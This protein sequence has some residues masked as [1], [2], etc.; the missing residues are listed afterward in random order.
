[1]WTRPAGPLRPVL[2]RNIPAT[3]QVALRIGGRELLTLHTDM[4]ITWR[5]DRT[6][7]LATDNI[8]L[9][10]ALGTGDAWKIYK[11]LGNL[12]TIAIANR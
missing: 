2:H 7:E 12:D 3:Q 11:N 5:P 4:F 9:E 8:M 1:M 6:N 10:H